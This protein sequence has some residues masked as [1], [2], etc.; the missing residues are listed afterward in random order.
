MN[1]NIDHSSGS[2]GECD[3]SI[4]IGNAN[5]KAR[6]DLATEGADCRSDDDEVHIVNL[7][8]KKS[9]LQSKLTEEVKENTVLQAS[10]EKRKEALHG[11]RIALEK[12]VENLRDQL[13]KERNLRSSL[14]SG[15][16]NMR[17]GQVSFPS[18]IDSKTKADLE[19]VAAAE[20]DI[21]NLKQKVS[22]LRGQLNNEVQLSST[23]LCESCSNNKRFL[24][25]DKL[26]EGGQN[27]VLSP[28]N[29]SSV[30]APPIVG[31]NSVPDMF[32]ATNQMVQKMLY[33]KGETL[34]DGQDGPLASRWNFSQRQYSNNPVMSRV[35][36]SNAY[37]SN[38]TEE[39]GAAP[40]SALAKLTSRLNFLKE[41]RALL[42][43]EMQNL[44]LGRSQA[45]GPTT[46]PP[47]RDSS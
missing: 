10:L 13:Q 38:K 33:S 29:S 14:E 37:S 26:V 22:D 15:L 25:A 39:S 46:L 6:K 3:S 19:E 36:G 20:A 31:S 8:N 35:Q 17:R 1:D 44:D 16:M 21:M 12:E 32:W 43:N 28:E 41:R 2:R 42:A 24:N 34:K 11:R 47:K 7:E 5:D 18:T 27:A 9:N 40:S 23:S 45:Q 30:E 4:K